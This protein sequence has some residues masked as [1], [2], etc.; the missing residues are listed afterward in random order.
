MKKI[1]LDSNFLMI[2]FQ[3]NID[4]FEEIKRICNFNYELFIIDKTIE[5]L[6]NLKEKEAKLALQLIKTKNIQQVTT[7]KDKIV[8]DL[9]LENLTENTIIATQDKGLKDRL[10]EKMIPMITL[11][12]K[13]HLILKTF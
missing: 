7:N 6:E 9:I 8:D 5:E 12:Q 11:R 1:I 4:I 2:P 10:K 3:F 13:K